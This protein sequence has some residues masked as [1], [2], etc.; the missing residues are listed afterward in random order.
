MRAIFFY[1]RKRI[2]EFVK[3]V[4]QE[5]HYREVSKWKAFAMYSY[6]ALLTVGA[7][8]FL[9]HLGKEIAEI[10]GLGQTFVGNILIALSTSLPE[11]V[12]SVAA[13]KIGAVDL[14]FGNVLGSNLFNVNI[15]ALDDIFYTKGPLLWHVSGGHMVS[16]IAAVTMT[17]LIILG[18]TYRTNKKFLFLAWDSLG[19]LAVY[20]LAVATL[21]T[22][23]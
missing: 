5:F 16:G 8:S 12:V 2:A 17:S 3:D 11:V 21:Y 15:L 7:A 4:A 9:P 14:A 1:D 19:I 18:L 22:T 10:T 6:N 20:M 13:L 23:G